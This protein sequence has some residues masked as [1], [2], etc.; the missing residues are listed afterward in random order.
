MIHGFAKR[1]TCNDVNF[2]QSSLTSRRRA[3]ASDA[4]ILHHA[5]QFRP[6]R[7]HQSRLPAD[8]YSYATAAEHNG[9]QQR[10]PGTQ[11]RT[12]PRCRGVEACRQVARLRACPNT[13]QGRRSAR[14]L[15]DRYLPRRNRT[16]DGELGLRRPIDERRLR[17]CCRRVNPVA[18]HR[19]RGTQV[20]RGRG[21]RL[22]TCLRGERGSGKQR[23]RC[24]N[25][26]FHTALNGSGGRL[27]PAARRARR[28]A[29]QLRCPSALIPVWPFR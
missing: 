2:R 15:G 9:V 26:K 27:W 10:I 7:N 11:R 3:T 24:S 8:A 17:A 18:L 21:G 19:S 22:R 5:S 28:A 6:C 23:E 29:G 25:W 4:A 13:E 14:G 16:L 12:Q 1:K 20:E